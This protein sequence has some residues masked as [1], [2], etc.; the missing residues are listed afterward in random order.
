MSNLLYLA[1]EEER[2]KLSESRV[3]HFHNFWL[4][5]K[6]RLE[7]LKARLN[8]LIDDKYYALYNNRNLINHTTLRSFFVCSVGLVIL[9][10]VA[11]IL[12]RTTDLNIGSYTIYL[13][14][15]A[16]IWIV[17]LL[18]YLFIRFYYLLFGKEKILRYEHLLTVKYVTEEMPHINKVYG[19]TG[20]GKDTFSIACSI[21]LSNYMRE[22]IISR[23]DDL[24]RILYIFDFDMVDSFCNTN[25]Y[26]FASYSYDLAKKAL[27][28]AL[29]TQKG[30]IRIKYRPT[31]KYK[32]LLELWSQQEANPN[33]FI[34]NLSYTD[35]IRYYALYQLLLEYILKYIRVYIEYN[36]IMANQ[37]LLEGGGIGAKKFS[38]NFL[39]IKQM[40]YKDHQEKYAS[41]ML[42]PWKDNIIVLETEA[43][44][45]YF[46]RDKQNSKEIYQSGVRDFK[47]YNRH[48]L[49]EMYWFT[50]DQDSSRVDKLLREL[51]HSYV[52]VLKKE[53]IPGG[54]KRTLWYTFLLNRI[55]NK[56]VKAENRKVK[57][58]LRKK[59]MKERITIYD[60]KNN[61]KKAR[62]Y[63]KKFNKV[64]KKLMNNEQL[65][66][67]LKKRKRY[68]EQ[69]DKAK[70]DGYIKMLITISDSPTPV[71]L[72]KI[73]LNQ[74]IKS[75]RL[76]YHSSFQTELTF[77]IKEVH[78]RYDTHYMRAVAERISKLS[79]YNFIDIPTWSPDLKI[80]K[81]DV[82]FMGYPASFEMFGITDEE[83][84]KYR[85]EKAKKTGG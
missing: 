8:T 22:S 71:N 64:K 4:K 15:L 19:K 49:N 3:H 69:I 66:K 73:T 55:S 1:P 57:L 16:G 35:G 21:I 84:K 75:D 52:Q 7:N 83:Y 47:A 61:E 77:M 44:S 40:E 41:K 31:I 53:V 24:K 48:F 17:Y 59:N 27:I 70:N 13:F 78:G 39:Q 42:F 54:I 67:Y 38:L 56:I 82:L 10:I 80:R 72:E 18:L 63:Q 62:I 14:I 25:Y 26:K 5:V 32:K 23:L 29:E 9:A 68:S 60:I 11:Y 65:D 46:N 76:M 79:D 50:N 20:A 58:E 43:G 37:P 2:E 36:F 33:Q 51:D 28:S 6:N 74:L 30:F 81:E 85:Y 12:I 34:S 45:W